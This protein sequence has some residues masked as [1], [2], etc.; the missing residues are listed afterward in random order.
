MPPMSLP[1]YKQVLSLLHQECDLA[2][3]Q[4]KMINISNYPTIKEAVTDDYF[5][6]SEL[7]KLEELDEVWRN[8][9]PY[10]IE[11]DIYPFIEL[12]GGQLLGVCSDTSNG[13][14]I[15]CLD[16]DF[17]LLQFDEGP[18]EMIAK[19][20]VIPDGWMSN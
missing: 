14:K 4:G 17:G 1:E 8:V 7:F 13:F 16:F 5:L 3:F 10:I 6:I 19:L 18:E 12:L 9:D 11:N 2:Q 15:C 20:E